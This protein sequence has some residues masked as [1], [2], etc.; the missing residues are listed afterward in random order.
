M[1]WNLEGERVMATYLDNAVAVTG[2]IYLS[3]VAYGG[4]VQHH[5]KLEQPFSVLG[6]AV[7]RDV[8][9]SVIVDHQN[10]LRVLGKG[11]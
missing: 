4:Q 5:V 7:K 9:E 1:S 8:G 11:E 3:R 6:G 2:T 10:V